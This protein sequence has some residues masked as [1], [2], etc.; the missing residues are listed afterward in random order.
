MQQFKR[1]R[2]SALFFFF[3]IVLGCLAIFLSFLILRALI[4]PIPLTPL[5]ADD[6]AL[7]LLS[8]RDLIVKI[9]ELETTIASY[10]ER[11]LQTSLLEEENNT[12]KAE[13]GREQMSGGVLARVVTP[14]KR[15]LYDTMVIDAG[16]R[17]GINEGAMVY[18][19]GSVAIGTIR[20]V[21]ES[22]ATVEL[23]SAPGRETTGTAEGSD[24]AITLIGR[25]AGEY[26]VR[27]PRD[28]SFVIGETISLQSIHTAVLARIEKIATD[29]RDPFQRLLAKAPVNLNALK[30]VIVR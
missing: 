27:M 2:H 14:P 24:V 17:E 6:A 18:A 19:F 11:L 29:P 1:Q 7:L 5:F 13:L 15:S 4:R 9:N 12:L 3:K 23:F 16:A 30:F 22:R 20:S 25:S 10:D 21:E 28:L 26:E 8:K